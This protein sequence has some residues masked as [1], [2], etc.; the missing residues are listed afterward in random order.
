MDKKTQYKKTKTGQLRQAEV[1]RWG[2]LL[3]SKREINKIA[4]PKR[5]VSKTYRLLQDI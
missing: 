4:L 1:P 2:L 5:A 3:N